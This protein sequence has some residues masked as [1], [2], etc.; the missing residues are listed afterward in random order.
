M[1]IVCV[2]NLETENCEDQLGKDAFFFNKTC[3]NATERPEYN[4]TLLN[5]SIG[6][7]GPAQEFFEYDLE[8]YYMPR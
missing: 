7:V 1:F 8:N 5:V 2:S 6:A 4:E 3:Y